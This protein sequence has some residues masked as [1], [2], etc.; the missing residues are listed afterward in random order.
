[1]TAT[2][3]GEIYPGVSEGLAWLREKFLLFVVSNCQ[4]GYVE[5]FLNFSGLTN[6]FLDIECWGNTGRPKSENL[7]SLIKRNSLRSPILFCQVCLRESS[8]LG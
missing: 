5:T 4:S 7:A 1:M 6:L 3:G 8:R 2:L